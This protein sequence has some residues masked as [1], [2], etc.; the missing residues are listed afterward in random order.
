MP[1]RER[2]KIQAVLREVGRA[3]G[4]RIVELL[5]HLTDQDIV[6]RERATVA[7]GHMG[8]AAAPGKDRIEA[9]LNQ[10]TT[11]REKRLI[12]WCLREIGRE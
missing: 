2:K 7:I 12:A 4:R 11:E 1:V 5:E 10:A 6:M 9:A 8:A 3:L